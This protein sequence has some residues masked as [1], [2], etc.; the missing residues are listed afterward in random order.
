ML[1]QSAIKYVSSVS[2]LNNGQ[3]VGF[4]HVYGWS[5]R[6]ANLFYLKKTNLSPK[7]L[8]LEIHDNIGLLLSCFNVHEIQHYGIII[9]ENPNC[10]NKIENFNIQEQ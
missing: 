5:I 3:N 8:D 9:L 4:G 10:I 7:T 1:S 2:M 6:G